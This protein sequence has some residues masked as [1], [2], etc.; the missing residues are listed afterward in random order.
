MLGPNCSLVTRVPL[1]RE[2]CAHYAFRVVAV[3]AGTPPL[4]SS[5]SVF[6]EVYYLYIY[7]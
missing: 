5:A 7:I 2:A 3:D 1:D 6:V 4:S